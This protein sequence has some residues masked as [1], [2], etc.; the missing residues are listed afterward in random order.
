MRER[1]VEHI[2]ANGPMPFDVFMEWCLYDPAEGFFSSGAVRSGKKG[3]FVTSPEIS[4][5]FGYCVGEWADNNTPSSGAAL[6][7]VGA[8]SGALL[9]E[10]VDLWVADGDSVYAVERSIEARNR[11]A[12]ALSNVRVLA[13]IDE[14]PRG[15][16]AVIVANEVLDNMPAALARRTAD[17]WAEI[18]VGAEADEL[19]LVDV[20]ARPDVTGWCDD[21]FGEAALGTTVSV[22]LAVSDWISHIFNRF[23]AVTMCLVDY[24]ATSEELIKRDPASIIRTYRK[25]QGGFDWL[26]HPGEVDITVDVNIN[27]LLKAIARQG[28]RARSMKQRDFVLENGLGE[29][30]ADARDGE[31]LAASKGAIMHQLENRSERLDMDALIDPTG[32]GAF[33][34]ILVE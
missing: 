4:W 7:E 8:G 25:H 30:I 9:R 14:I 16:D 23:G 2:Q 18:A 13:S 28:R 24:G 32:L 33:E 11:L 26:Q 19:V 21:A 10:M 17:G 15:I 34:V 12:A 27:G 5:A 20:Q 3:D 6:V 1:I 31:Q 29:I 22:Q